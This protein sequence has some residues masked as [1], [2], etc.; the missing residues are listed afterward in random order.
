MPK[1]DAKRIK[2]LGIVVAVL[3]SLLMFVLWLVFITSENVTPEA[4]ATMIGRPL[5]L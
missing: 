1:R 3:G 4:I 2:M 5:F